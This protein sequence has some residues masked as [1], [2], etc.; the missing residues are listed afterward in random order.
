MAPDGSV[1]VED[2]RLAG[3]TRLVE[4]DDGIPPRAEGELSRARPTAL[5]RALAAR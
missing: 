1:G 4:R 3:T 5:A 2:R